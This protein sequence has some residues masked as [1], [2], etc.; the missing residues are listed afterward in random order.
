MWRNLFETHWTECKLR[1]PIEN[2]VIEKCQDELSVAVPDV[3]LEFYNESDGVLGPD[4]DFLILP[5][6]ELVDTNVDMWLNHEYEGVFMPFESLLFFA[7][8]RTDNMF[9]YPILG[10]RADSDKIYKWKRETDSRTFYAN[11][12]E[13]YFYMQWKCFKENNPN[14]WDNEI[15][16]KDFDDYRLFLRWRHETGS[17]SDGDVEVTIEGEFSPDVDMS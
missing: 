2:S 6:Q 10:E 8:D 9:A 7:Y 1:D 17:P 11:G 3:L 16:C 4:G 5:M 13:Q 14:F 12:L 15:N